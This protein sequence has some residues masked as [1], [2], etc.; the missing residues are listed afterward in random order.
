M[1]HL[2]T[3]IGLNFTEN[4]CLAPQGWGAK[5]FRVVMLLEWITLSLNTT[6]P[7]QSVWASEELEPNHAGD[8][9]VKQGRLT[10]I[11]VD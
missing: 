11:V 10:K 6:V 7:L 3:Q 2:R 8:I 9:L 4:S 5:Q 1:L